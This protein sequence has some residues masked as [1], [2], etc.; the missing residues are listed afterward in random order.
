MEN[1]KKRILAFDY[2]EIP[3]YY[4][5]NIRK[6]VNLTI[7]RIRLEYSIFLMRTFHWMVL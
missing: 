6:R 3:N 2:E 4:S 7:L 5:D 1:A